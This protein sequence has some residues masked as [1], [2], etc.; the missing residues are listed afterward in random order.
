MQLSAAV[1]TV[2]DIDARVDWHLQS[3]DPA[4]LISTIAQPHSLLAILS[5]DKSDKTYFVTVLVW[6]EVSTK[7]KNGIVD[8]LM[9]EKP[10][11]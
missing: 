6:F 2:Y 4:K 1:P 10:S 9:T 5:H 8:I 11:Q 3:P 7:S